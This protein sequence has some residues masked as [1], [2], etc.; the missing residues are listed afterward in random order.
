[1]T[2]MTAGPTTDTSTRQGGTAAPTSVKGKGATDT[3]SRAP[4]PS[5]LTREM[6]A[7]MLASHQ[8]APGA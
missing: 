2:T 4:D 8:P 6:L 5:H 7:V 3:S 1:M